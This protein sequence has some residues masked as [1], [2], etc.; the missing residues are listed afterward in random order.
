MLILATTLYVG[1]IE[2]ILLLYIHLHYLATLLTAIKQVSASALESGIS[3]K[4][5]G[6]HL[7]VLCSSVSFLLALLNCKYMYIV[8]TA[9]VITQLHLFNSVEG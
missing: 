4:E 1:T 6:K 5:Y 8:C 7:N 9:S 2:A 3:F